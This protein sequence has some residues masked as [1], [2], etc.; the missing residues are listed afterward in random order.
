MLIVLQR[1]TLQNSFAVF[2][3]LRQNIASVR[4]KEM[5]KIGISLPAEVIP[6][7]NEIEILVDQL[8]NRISRNR[9]AIGNLAHELKRPLQLLSLQLENSW[10]PRSSEATARYSHHYRT[11]S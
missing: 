10:R 4:H 6:L 11:A 8:R 3:I 5:E 9:H 2:E 7:I 1:R